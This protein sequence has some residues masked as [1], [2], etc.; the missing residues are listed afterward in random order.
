MSHVLDRTAQ[1]DVPILDVLA[2][3]WS[4]RVFDA[5]SPIDEEAL[6][7][8]LEA[9]R[10]SPSANNSQP[11]RFLLAR[12]GT[13][14]HAR[15]VDSLVGFNQGWAPAAGALLVVLAESTDAEGNARPWAT[16]DAGQAAAFFTIQAHA[17]GLATHTMGG[18]SAD[19]L[20]TAFDIDARFTPVTVIAVGAFGDPD[21]ADEAVRAREAT[22][23]ARRPLAETLLLDA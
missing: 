23:R 9:A 13:D 3:R 8:A 12:R 2:E 7:A 1:T 11:W 6:R 5:E 22:P 17:R 19:A 10:W 14:A 18:F 15:I 20:R 4:T 21:A 16:Y